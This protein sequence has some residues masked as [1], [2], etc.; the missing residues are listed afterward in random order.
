MT[1]LSLLVIAAP[2]HNPLA[3]LPQICHEKHR[4]AI[5]HWDFLEHVTTA[6]T[7]AHTEHIKPSLTRA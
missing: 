6:E 3:L 7:S 1:K 2:L 4:R 5:D